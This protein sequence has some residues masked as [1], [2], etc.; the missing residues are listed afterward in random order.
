M[1]VLVDSQTTR[2]EK[3]IERIRKTA[4]HLLRY[5]GHI[6]SELSVLL[7]DDKRISELNAA[8]R[9]KNRPT[10]VLSFPML[11]QKSPGMPVLL[12]D[13]VISVETAVREAGQQE[14]DPGDYLAVLLVHG[15]IHLLGFDHEKGEKEAEDMA[16]QE[17]LHLKKLQKDKLINLEVDNLMSLK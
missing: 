3:E 8:Y 11:E 16:A 2:G 14:I 13:I 10:N 6:D 9:R 5:T 4:D 1:T 12:G 7:V 17:R 15:F